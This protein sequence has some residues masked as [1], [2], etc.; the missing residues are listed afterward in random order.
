MGWVLIWTC[1]SKAQAQAPVSY[2]IKTKRG[3]WALPLGGNH[4]SPARLSGTSETQALG[5]AQLSKHSL[6]HISLLFSPNSLPFLLTPFPFYDLPV[7]L[8]L[9]EASDT[10][11]PS[12][13]LQC[14]LTLSIHHP[15]W[16]AG[17]CVCHRIHTS[18]KSRTCTGSNSNA[19]S[20]RTQ[21]QTDYREEP[22][23]KLI[24]LI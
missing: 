10:H 1:L 4:N 14:F 7:T 9:R 12:C 15:A 16:V 22:R 23:Q 17:V 13:G 20:G 5:H 3:I 19:P 6:P 2:N 8:G 21:T 18:L 24:F 11:P